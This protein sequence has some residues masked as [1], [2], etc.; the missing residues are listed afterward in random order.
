MKTIV[1]VLVES[2]LYFTLSL[3]DRYGLVK[4]LLDR[5]TS[6]DLSA[7]HLKLRAFLTVKPH[8]S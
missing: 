8:G 7:M 5:E 6:I 1:A 4:R 3:Q 2:P